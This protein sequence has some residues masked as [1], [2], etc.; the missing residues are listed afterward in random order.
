MIMANIPLEAQEA[1]NAGLVHKVYP[2]ETFD[3][4]VMAFC[5][6]LAKQ[7]AE[8]VGA[9]KVAIELAAD[10]PASQAAL[11]ERLVNSSIMISPHYEELMKSHLAN[12]GKGK[13]Y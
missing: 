4:D 11:V 6:H 8:L 5:R 13:G 3:D 1:L 7:D 12:I 9:A 2:D 10:L